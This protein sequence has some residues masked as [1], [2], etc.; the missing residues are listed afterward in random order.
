MS[1]GPAGEINVGSLLQG[2]EPRRA[3]ELGVSIL[4]PWGHLLFGQGHQAAVLAP[5]GRGG[6]LG[7]FAVVAEERRPSELFE[8][9]LQQPR[10]HG[11]PSIRS[12][13]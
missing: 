1:L 7:D 9:G 12:W 3:D 8:V 10:C 13:S 2:G 6:C 4:L 5:S 11:E